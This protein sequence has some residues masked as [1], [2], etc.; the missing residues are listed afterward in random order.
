MLMQFEVLVTEQFRY[1]SLEGRMEEKGG[2][3]EAKRHMAISGVK[4]TVSCSEL[5]QSSGL[6][7]EGTARWRM[8]GVC[9][10]KHWVR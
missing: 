7:H 2:R 1:N 6:V 5:P 8:G 9:G 10:V 3:R 4:E